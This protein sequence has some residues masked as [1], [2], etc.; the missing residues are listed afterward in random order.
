MLWIIENGGKWSEGNG[1]R[2]AEIV[3]LWAE[4]ELCISG[5]ESPKLTWILSLSLRFNRHFPGEPGLAG[6]YWQKGW[7][8]R[9]WLVTTGAINRAK[10]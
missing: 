9:W 10:L 2:E 5:A 6:V 4:Y 1:A 3:K 7:W 8:K